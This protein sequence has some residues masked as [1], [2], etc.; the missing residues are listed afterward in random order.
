MKNHYDILGISRKATQDEIKTAYRKLSV[1]FHPDKNDGEAFFTEMFKQI[2][3]AYS[4][5]YDTSKRKIYDNQLYQFENPTSK[6]AYQE[7]RREQPPPPV[8]K[9]YSNTGYNS[10]AINSKWDEVKKWQK[11]KHILLLINC[12]LV[13][14]IFILPKNSTSTPTPEVSPTDTI[15]NKSTSL[16]KHRKH[17]I[18]LRHIQQTNSGTVNYRD[19][20][21]NQTQPDKVTS[22][23][24]APIIQEKK[25]LPDTIKTEIKKKKKGFFRRLFGKKDTS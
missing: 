14:F 4:V 3:E 7:V 13:L 25:A 17:K 8:T 22:D 18:T 11:A 23:S 21:Q 12:L 15:Q 24:I 6:N 5:L 20:V 16:R 9:T 19:S 1:K 2:N 10:S